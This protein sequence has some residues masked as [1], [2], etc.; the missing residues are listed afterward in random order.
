MKEQELIYTEKSSKPSLLKIL[1]WI[2]LGD[3]VACILYGIAMGAGGSID[4]QLNGAPAFLAEISVIS[5]ILAILFYRLSGKRI[6]SISI[7]ERTVVFSAPKYPML[8]DYEAVAENLEQKYQEKL[9]EEA[10][11]TREN[12]YLR[13]R[14][15]AEP[16]KESVPAESTESTESADSDE[17]PMKIGK[18]THDIPNSEVECPMEEIRSASRKGKNV[19]LIME[20]GDRYLFVRMSGAAR[21][22]KVIEDKVAAVVK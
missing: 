20:N 14:R 17:E 15:Q 1:L 18:I 4:A 12:P 9:A 5:V 13:K 21:L 7:Y 10:S 11:E 16:P 6:T 2:L 3:F 22:V 19:T 8:V